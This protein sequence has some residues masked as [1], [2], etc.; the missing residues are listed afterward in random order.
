M[1]TF[2]EILQEARKLKPEEKRKLGV[3]LTAERP[4]TLE[5]LAA[6]QGKG[7]VNF[8]ELL[9]LGEFWPEEESVDDFNAFVRESRRGDP[10]K[11]IAELSSL[12]D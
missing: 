12:E 7:P 5:E 1:L 3:L 2:E 11:G 8:D 6:E 4:T 10:F 9:K